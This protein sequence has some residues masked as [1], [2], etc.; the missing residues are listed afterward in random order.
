MCS[1]E[2]E[3]RVVPCANQEA[4]ARA[5][6]LR[7]VASRAERGEEGLRQLRLLFAGTSMA[8]YCAFTT[9]AFIIALIVEAAEYVLTREGKTSVPCANQ[10]AQARAAGLR[11]VASRAERGEE[12]LRLLFAGTSMEMYCAVTT[13]AVYRCVDCGGGGI[14]AHKR[15]KHIALIVEAPEMCS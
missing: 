5:A 14:C 9:V 10:E 13:V 8:R 7:S 4:K 1:Q 2:K 12:G 11:S 3:R 15:Q 6:G